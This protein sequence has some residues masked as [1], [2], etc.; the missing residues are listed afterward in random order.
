M[1]SLRRVLSNRRVQIAFLIFT[2]TAVLVGFRYRHSV[3]HT[4]RSN[5]LGSSHLAGIRARVQPRLEEEAA[6]KGSAL[7]SPVYIRIFKESKELELWLQKPGT[8]KKF[9]L[10]K[11]YPIR[12]FGRG[13][14]GPKLAEGDGQAPTGFYTVTRAQMKPD[15]AYH[16]AF[17]LGFPNRYDVKKGRTGSFL[18]VHGDTVSIGCYAMTDPLIEEIYLLVDAALAGGQ[19][20]VPVHAFPFRMTEERMRK[21]APSDKEKQW[22]REWQN[23]KTG[24]DLFLRTGTPPIARVGESGLYEFD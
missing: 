3:M 17:N 10:F 11:S 19:K 4:L 2:W 18:M 12:N 23:L 22:L 9:A 8:Q 14:L 16:L 20:A 5:I 13:T 24:H 7:G 1:N 6:A 15:S 21:A